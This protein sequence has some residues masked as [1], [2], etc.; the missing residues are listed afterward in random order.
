MVDR[1][2]DTAF[3]LASRARVHF[4]AKAYGLGA[5]GRVFLLYRAGVD[6]Q[7]IAIS[8]MKAKGRGFGRS[9]RIA[10]HRWPR[11][12]PISFLAQHCNMQAPCSPSA[13]SSFKLMMLR[14]QGSR[15]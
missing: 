7:D 11:P 2:V 14:Y 3:L 12:R 6:T 1:G 5:D 4:P 15:H 13:S 9:I 10:T 8:E